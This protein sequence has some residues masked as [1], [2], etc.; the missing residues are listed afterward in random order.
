MKGD[1]FKFPDF[2]K[3]GSAVALRLA[4]F[5]NNVKF[6]MQFEYF[7]IGQAADKQWYAWY[8]RQRTHDEI[9]KSSLN[10]R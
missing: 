5:K 10:G 1:I 7:D 8:Y 9:Q 3:A 6:G 2:V 4:M